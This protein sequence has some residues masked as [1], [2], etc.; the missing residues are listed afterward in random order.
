[1]PK[2]QCPECEAILRRET[3]VPEGKKIK[4]PKCESLFKPKPM[5]DADDEREQVK[6][7][8]KAVPKSA[9]TDDQ[10]D[11]EGGAYDVVGEKDEPKKKDVHYGSL[12]DKFKKSKR[13]PAMAKLCKLSNGMLLIGIVTGIVGL[14]GVMAGLW[15]FIFS[16]EMPRGSRRV[17][18]I[19]Q[20]LFSIFVFGYGAC[21]CYGGSKMHDLKSYG[22]SMAASF[23]TAICGIVILA[24]TIYGGYVQFS[25]MEEGNGLLQMVLVL[26]IG[27]LLAWSLFS[28]SVGFRSIARLKEESIK[29]GFEETQEMRDY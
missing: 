17:F 6:K 3:A 19:L 11:E 1:M 15:P 4:C 10:D 13:G 2:Y 12:R 23:L 29:E 24:G 20:I 7:K 22:W 16:Q 8:A 27:L 9:P 26:V 18:Y 5:Q 21:I 14:L 25:G 28:C